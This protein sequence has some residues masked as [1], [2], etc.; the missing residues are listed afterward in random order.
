M[1]VKKYTYNVLCCS[2]FAVFFCVLPS[3][4]K[5]QDAVYSQFMF[6]A[7]AVNPALTGISDYN[8]LTIGFRDQ[9]V[10]IPHAYVT[11]FASYDQKLELYNSGIGFQLYRDVAGGVYSR[12]S[13]E[14]FYSY[15]FEVSNHLTVSTGLQMGIVQRALDASKFTFPEPNPVVTVETRS[16][17]FPDFGVG[18]LANFS[19]RYSLGV[20][21]HHINAPV[22]TLSEINQKRTP[23]SLSAHIISYFPFYFGFFDRYQFVFSPG[24][25]FRTQQ[26]QNVLTAGM[27]V[28]YDPVFVGLW[29]RTAGEFGPESLIFMAGL[30]LDNFR[31]V[32]NHDYKLAHLK[33][34]FIGTGA[35]EIVVS[36]KIHPP[37]KMRT[38]KCSKFSLESMNSRSR[39]R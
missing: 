34:E 39:K 7:L 14:A 3:T 13:F 12:T 24:A 1:S 10:Q 37:K 26:N 2:I 32:Y 25:Y 11:F 20:A 21:A 28:A 27:N 29:L 22:E 4:V 16:R 6:D 5:A 15:Q 33:G 35:H 36:W 30:E 9:W 19:D 31:V 8:K 18:V 38:I 17:L 23:M